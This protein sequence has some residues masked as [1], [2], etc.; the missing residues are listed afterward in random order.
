MESTLKE[1]GIIQKTMDLCQAVAEQPDFQSLK[2]K[3]DAFMG[4]E[5]VKFQYQQVNDLNNLLQ[6]KQQDGL[7]LT[8]EEIAKFDVLREELLKN[9]VALG[10]FEA[11]KELQKLHEAV[12]RFVNKTFEL[13]RRPEYEDV[14]DGSCTDCGCH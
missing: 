10:F 6:M 2:Q 11:Q 9:P 7:D 12:G 4:N 3:L 8:P 14:Y 1:G 5:L 13:G